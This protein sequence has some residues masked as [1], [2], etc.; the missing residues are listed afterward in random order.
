[1][2]TNEILEQYGIKPAPTSTFIE[3]RVALLKKLHEIM[4]TMNNEE[5]YF[6]WI[7]CVP[8][9]PSE[10]DFE[11]FAESDSEWNHVLELF[12]KL[13]HEYKDDE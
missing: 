13:F 7:L 2:N 11:F 12:E 10:E 5:C 4:L 8:D 9:E 3:S 1:M 6:T